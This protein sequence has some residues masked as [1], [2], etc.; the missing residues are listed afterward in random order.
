MESYWIV[1]KITDKIIIDIEGCIESSMCINWIN[2]NLRKFGCVLT[3]KFVWITIWVNDIKL[4]FESWTKNQ[5]M[6]PTCKLD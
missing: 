5:N 4:D 2:D 6:I 3:V 1:L